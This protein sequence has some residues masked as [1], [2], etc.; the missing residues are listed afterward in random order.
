MLKLDGDILQVGEGVRNEEVVF[1]WVQLCKSMSHD[2][3][4]RDGSRFYGNW[5]PDSGSA[6]GRGQ[7]SQRIPCQSSCICPTLQVVLEDGKALEGTWKDGKLVGPVR[8]V[9]S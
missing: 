6:E 5:N 1:K 9:F 8:Q 3:S 7:V 2:G 4:F